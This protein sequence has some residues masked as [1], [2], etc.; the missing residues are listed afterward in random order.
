MANVNRRQMLGIVGG[1]MA[2]GVGASVLGVTRSKPAEAAYQS[3]EPEK[4]FAWE[5]RKLP[6]L[7]KVQAVARERFYHNG[8]G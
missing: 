4:G 1:A 8:W 6:D 2:A 7:N 3:T 5:P